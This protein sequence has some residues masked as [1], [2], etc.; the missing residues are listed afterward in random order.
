M[1][2]IREGLKIMWYY[3][4]LY[5][6]AIISTVVITY[7]VLTR[8]R[9]VEIPHGKVMV[10]LGKQFLKDGSFEIV[11]S[12]GKHIKP[13]YES[14]EFLDVTEKEMI[15]QLE[16]IESKDGELFHMKAIVTYKIHEEMESLK[17]AAIMLMQKSHDEIEYIVLKTSE[18]HIRGVCAREYSDQLNL[19]NERISQK[20]LE[21][22]RP[23]SRTI[24]LDVVSMKIQSMKNRSRHESSNKT[25]SN[26][27]D[28]NQ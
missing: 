3:I 22:V 7:L 13:I 14:H 11:T 12:G 1:V 4:L 16:N 19:E 15:I 28:N 23:D 9:F 27:N 24:G 8:K 18:G 25:T 21:M 10:F 5:A 2:I 17:I 20:I 26:N 6:V